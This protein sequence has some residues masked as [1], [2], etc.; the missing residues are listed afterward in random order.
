M[1]YEKAEELEGVM[2]LVLDRKET[3]NALSVRMVSEIRESIANIA[4]QSS[5]RVLLLTTPHPGTFCSGADLRER[6]SMSPT[7]VHLFLDSLR[8]MISELEALP[9]PTIAVIDGPAL[10]GGAELALGCDMRVGGQGTVIGLP[11]VKLGIIPGAGGTQR[12]ARLM[13]GA[14]AK[15]VVFTGR[16]L[17]GEEAERIGFLNK[18]AQPPSTPLQEALLLSRQITTSAPLALAAAKK[19]IGA[20]TDSTMTLEQGLDLERKLY[21]PLLGTEDRGEGLRAFKDKRRARFVGR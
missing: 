20:A 21:D 9:I 12:L 14:R 2:A 3:R 8:A 13:G 7:S 11:E 17:G 10:G 6:L 18:F 19:A 16:R 1:Q 5:A 15:E 4:A